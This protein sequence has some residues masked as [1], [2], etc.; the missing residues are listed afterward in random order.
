MAPY[1]IKNLLNL[2]FKSRPRPKWILSFLIHMVS[3][4][5]FSQTVTTF[6]IEKLSPPKN[7]LKEGSQN[8]NL[9]SFPQIEKTSSLP[10]SFVCYGNYSFIS[11]ILTAYREHRPFV[12]SPDIFWLLISQGFSRHIANNAEEFRKDFVNFEGKIELCTEETSIVLGRPNNDWEQVFPQFINQITAYT[13]KELVNILTADFSTTTSASKIAS[14]ITIME[15]MKHYFDYKVKGVGCGL[16]KITI[17]GSTADWEKVLLKTQF[18]SKYKLKWW[19]SKLE[20]I[21]MEIISATKGNFNKKFWMRMVKD[22]T[23]ATYGNPGSIDGWIVKFFPYG[24]DGKKRILKKIRNIYSL[25]SEIIRVPFIFEDSTNQLKFKMEFCAGFVGLTQDKN[26]FTL[27]PQIGWIVNHKIDM[28]S[29]RKR[30]EIR[31]E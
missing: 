10:D 31:Q 2:G 12:I 1:Q 25:P 26:D 20:P 16:P 27:K 24:R 3:I 7:L 14:Q 15:T 18:I 8:E 11:G 23:E 4:G 22:H 21:L 5:G 9:N 6:E 30:R 28:P 19:T 29:F 13:S 17:E